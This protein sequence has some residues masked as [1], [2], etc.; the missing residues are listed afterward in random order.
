M[1]SGLGI[2][3]SCADDRALSLDRANCRW[4]AA[5]DEECHDCYLICGEDP[6][7]AC[8]SHLTIAATLACDQSRSSEGNL[9]W[10]LTVTIYVHCACWLD[11]VEYA[12]ELQCAYVGDVASAGACPAIGEYTLTAVGECDPSTLVVTIGNPA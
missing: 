7:D 9:I 1:P 10:V 6:C 8:Y 11:D 12:Y 5:V 3:L 4:T 2:P